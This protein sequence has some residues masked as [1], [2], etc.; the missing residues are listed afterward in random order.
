[1]NDTDRIALGRAV[2]ARNIGVG[3]AEAEELMVRRAGRE[4]TT[5]AF[6]AAG[7]MGWGS[8]QLTDRDRAMAVIASL[9][10]QHVTDDRLVTYLTLARSTGVTEEG[11]TA[12]MI[13][14]TAYVG[15]PAASAAM[16]T[17]RRTAVSEPSP[18]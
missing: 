6:N 2:Y 12:L 13:L 4:Y 5:E 1:M 9:V 11:L 14:L 18:S 7:G 3:E 15:Q 10:G 17:V 8:D 16:A